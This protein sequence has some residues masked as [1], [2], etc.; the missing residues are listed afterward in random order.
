[1]PAFLMED[2]NV[3]IPCQGKIGLNSDEISTY[4][5][6]GYVMSR[7]RHR[8]KENQVIS[9]EEKRGFLKSQKEE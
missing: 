3:H 8:Q 7:S 1:M 9:A 2:T 4:E 6:V 5:A